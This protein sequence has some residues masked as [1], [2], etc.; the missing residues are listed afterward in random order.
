[1]GGIMGENGGLFEESG[2]SAVARLAI[3]TSPVRAK[4][5]KPWTMMNNM[6]RMGERMSMHL[7]GSSRIWRA[8]PVWI[9]GRETVSRDG[10]FD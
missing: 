1:M 9:K 6:V 2:G 7:L 4:K 8:R 3:R 10:W 5:E